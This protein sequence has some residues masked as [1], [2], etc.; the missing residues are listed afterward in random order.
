MNSLSYDFKALKQKAKE[1]QSYFIQSHKSLVVAESLTGGLVSHLLTLNPG[2]SQFFL[3]GVVCYSL[4]AK[5]Q[6][7]G[8]PQKLLKEQGAVNESVCRLMAQ[9]VKKNG[10]VITLFPL[11]A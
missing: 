9:G 2:A 10:V 7:L 6:Q 1:L 3:G 8:I 11:Q 4:S 5:T